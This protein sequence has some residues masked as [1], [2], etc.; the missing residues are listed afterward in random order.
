MDQNQNQ[1][2]NDP[3]RVGGQGEM[4]DERVKSTGES[5]VTPEG[6]AT[7][8]PAGQQQRRTGPDTGRARGTDL[9]SSPGTTERDSTGAKGAPGGMEGAPGRDVDA[10][11]RPT[12]EDAAAGPRERE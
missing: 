12:D 10:M 6:P 9:P 2:Q 1:N 5:P 3:R 4:G 7:T 11:P 8:M